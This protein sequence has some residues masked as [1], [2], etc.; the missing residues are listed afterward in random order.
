MALSFMLRWRW[1]SG[2]RMA[3]LYVLPLWLA[4]L[5]SSCS[6]PGSPSGIAPPL[7]RH[8]DEAAMPSS[9]R[10]HAFF[11]DRDG[12]KAPYLVDSGG[13]DRSRTGCGLIVYLHG[14]GYEEYPAGPEGA[15]DILAAYAGLARRHGM[16]M[17]APR[18]PDTGTGTWWQ[19]DYP[20]QWL[21][22]LIRHTVQRYRI[23]RRQIWF[24]GYSGGAEVLSY[25]IMADHSDLF[26]GGGAVMIGGGGWHENA[27]ISRPLGA[28]L[29]HGFIL[30]WLVGSLDTA[31]GRP[32]GDFDALAAARRGFEHYRR[33]GV[34][35]LRFSVLEGVGH[36]DYG[37]IGVDHLE[38]LLLQRAR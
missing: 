10:E 32:D 22:G 12:H 21:A 31:G 25:S 23:D 35:N 14:D 9:G 5:C 7:A 26:E 19:A 1:L 20:A 29:R 15:T 18:T 11:T 24:V 27:S 30:S 8:G 28:R 16:V 4:A 17:I 6:V 2:K 36:F 13:C 38:A 33:A 34:R 3:S 37:R